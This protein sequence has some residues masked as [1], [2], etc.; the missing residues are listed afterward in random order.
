[1]MQLRYFEKE[2]TK[3]A[4]SIDSIL[5]RCKSI[6]PTTDFHAMSVYHNQTYLFQE[7]QFKLI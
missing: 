5:E 6:E 2:S 7:S 1:M 3:V 4:T